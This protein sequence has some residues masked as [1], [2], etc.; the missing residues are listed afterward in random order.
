MPSTDFVV[1]GYA[2][3]SGLL[4][5]P[6]CIDIMGDMWMPVGWVVD[7]SLGDPGH[8][9]ISELANNSNSQADISLQGYMYS[10]TS[11][12]SVHVGG[13]ICG[14]SWWGPPAIFERTYR[15]PLKAAPAPPATQFQDFVVSA[16]APGYFG[17]APRCADIDGNLTALSGW[18]VDRN[19]GDPGH[20]GVSELANKSNPQANAS[21]Q[22]Y[23]YEAI[24]D[25]AVHVGGRICG[26]AWGGPG[27][28]FE[29]TY[30][31]FLVPA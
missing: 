9:G 13:R 24:S 18:V 29:R 15:V 12:R 22:A 30:R 26:A 31:V 2:P 16:Y 6:R 10:A 14:G 1:S 17:F 4:G 11:D 27:A 20:P 25:T 8:P 28:V 7:P 19:Q 21:L 5:P 23:M 3:S